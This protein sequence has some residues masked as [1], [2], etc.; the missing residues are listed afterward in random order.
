MSTM[1]A[2]DPNVPMFREVIGACGSGIGVLVTRVMVN[3]SPPSTF[4]AD[5]VPLPRR[6]RQLHAG[7]N[8]GRRTSCSFVVPARFANPG[9]LYHVT[10]PRPAAWLKNAFVSVVGALTFA[11]RTPRL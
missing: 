6:T 2:S 8:S 9:P 7:A 4:D 11:V 3:G 5:D 1:E 10:F